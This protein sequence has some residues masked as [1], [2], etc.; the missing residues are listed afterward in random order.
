MTRGLL[1]PLAEHGNALAQTYV[2]FMYAIAVI[3][4]R[5][6]LAS[7][8][9]DAWIPRIQLHMQFTGSPA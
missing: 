8:I 2:G 3:A 9:G 4:S 1:L 6:L 5:D 7:V